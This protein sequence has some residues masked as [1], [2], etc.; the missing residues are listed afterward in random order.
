[1][2]LRLARVDTLHDRR[3]ERRTNTIFR[4]S[5][6]EASAELLDDGLEAS[7]RLGCRDKLRVLR[8]LDL[9]KLN[10]GS[11]TLQESTLDDFWPGRFDFRVCNFQEQSLDQ[12]VAVLA[13]VLCQRCQRCFLQRTL[14][15]GKLENSC[16]TTG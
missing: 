3:Q 6:A 13:N 5:S 9:Q 15:L 7:R 14:L 12:G 4:R 2:F 1:M 8:V 10:Q 11:N 16:L